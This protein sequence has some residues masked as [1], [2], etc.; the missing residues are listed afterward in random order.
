M[1][2]IA[3]IG[4][5][6]IL[7]HSANTMIDIAKVTVEFCSNGFAKEFLGAKQTFFVFNS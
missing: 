5:P 4:A 7:Y 2:K 1:G 6:C 3:G